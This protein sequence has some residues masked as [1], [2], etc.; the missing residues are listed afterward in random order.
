MREDER[1]AWDGA[2]DAHTP[3]AKLSLIFDERLIR[4]NNTLSRAGDVQL[5]PSGTVEPDVLAV[6]NAAVPL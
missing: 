3:L 2:R 4:I 1:S 6:L 5:L